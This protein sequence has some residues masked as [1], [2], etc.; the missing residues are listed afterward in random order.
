MIYGKSLFFLG[1][2]GVLAVSDLRSF[3]C[4]AHHEVK[5]AGSSFS[6]ACIS[7]EGNCDADGGILTCKLEAAL[8]QPV[9]D[10]IDVE[11]S[12]FFAE[13]E[14]DG[15]RNGSIHEPIAKSFGIRPQRRNLLAP[16]LYRKLGP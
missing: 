3:R 12:T 4:V 16:R 5:R 10:L 2:L 15:L 8:K 1:G 6:K 7:V 11:C 14:S 13:Q 9:V